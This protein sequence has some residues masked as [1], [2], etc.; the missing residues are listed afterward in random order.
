MNKTFRMS[1]A[2]AVIAAA[3]G[4]SSMAAAQDTATVTAKVEVLKPLTLVATNDLDFGQLVIA[5]VAQGGSVSL[6][7]DANP[8]RTCSADLVCSGLFTV[9]ELVVSGG[10]AGKGVTVN[11]PKNVVL[12]LDGALATSTDAS[13]LIELVP[14]LNI[15]QDTTVTSATDNFYKTTLSADTAADGGGIATFYMGGDIALDGSEQAGNYA[16]DFNVS[17]E[18][19]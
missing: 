7:A 9:P 6:T 5:D 12:R 11:V 8:A 15:T 16:A 14:T 4:M 2:G 13:E 18:Y 1:A 10:T 17:V 19:S 3:M